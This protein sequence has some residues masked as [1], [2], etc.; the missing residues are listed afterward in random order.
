MKIE[1]TKF[2]DVFI[3]KPKIINDSRGYFFES[4]NQRVF[5]EK[6][7]SKIYFIQDNEAQS[8]YGVIRGL[9]YQEPPYNQSKL[10]RVVNGAI[11]DIVVDIKMDSETFGEMLIVK[12]DS[13]KKEQ[14][15]IPRGYAHGYVAIENGTIIHYKVDNYYAPAFESGILFNSINIDFKN[16]IGHEDFKISEKDQNL[17]SFTDTIFFKTSEYYQ[18]F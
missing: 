12:L 5:N 14:L 6:L 4:Y 17:S 10:V 1:K 7:N 13:Q 15:F 2:N 9:H 18:N 3:L 16:E 8:E 11:I